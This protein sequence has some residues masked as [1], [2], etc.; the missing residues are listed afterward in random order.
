M[1]AAKPVLCI[2]TP[3]TRRANN[4]NWRT[5]ARWAQMLR[6]RY[7]VIVQ[8]EWDGRDCDAM[9]ALHA[10]R[11]AG[12][13]ARFHEAKGSRHLA[14]VLSGTDLYRDL[15]GSAEARRS[16]DVAGRIVVL[17]DEARR[18]LEPRWRRKALVIYQS[19]E[20][21]SRE[22]R[23]AGALHCVA[24]GH[25]RD[26]KDPL[27][28][29]AAIERLPAGLPIRLVHIGEAL[30]GELGAEARALAAREPRY[31]Y[32]GPLPRARTRAA[33]A[34]AN[35]LVHPSKMEGGANVVVEAVASGTPVIA[36][37]IPG[38]VGMLGRRYGG[39]FRV[40]DASGLARRL[41][42]ACEDPRYLAA[43]AR[44]CAARRPL[45][46]PAAEARAIRKLAKS[47]L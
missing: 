5:A 43:L 46:A 47:L 19:T 30:D 17:Q 3:G 7:R 8:T 45:F 2:V 24:V 40:G 37:G 38:N 34:R 21:V 22:R 42:Q 32:A 16:L 15:P 10:R 12:S 25:L 13:I 28:L 6:D 9:I 33:I 36:S 18:A 27:T 39:Y 44:A 23:R 14:V 20:P 35:V 11:S 31:V 26:E 4:G 1:P 41:V 29:F